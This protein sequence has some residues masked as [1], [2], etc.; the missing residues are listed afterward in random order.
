MDKSQEEEK[1]IHVCMKHW[2]TAVQHVWH[3]FRQFAPPPQC[4][5]MG[6]YFYGRAILPSEN[7][8][9]SDVDVYVDVPNKFFAHVKPILQALQGHCRD[10]KGVKRIDLQWNNNTLKVR[11]KRG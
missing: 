4:K 5:L 3:G 10:H 11:H 7:T 6:L 1:I 8:K 9:A 2:Q